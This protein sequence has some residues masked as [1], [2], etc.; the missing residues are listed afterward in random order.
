MQRAG[1]II[2]SD[3]PYADE[4]AIEVQIGGVYEADMGQ[5]CL[6]PSIRLRQKHL[7]PRCVRL[8]CHLHGQPRLTIEWRPH[9]NKP[10]AAPRPC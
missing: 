8:E 4:R 5:L 7:R 10:N 3:G 1:N 2:R 9:A 6:T